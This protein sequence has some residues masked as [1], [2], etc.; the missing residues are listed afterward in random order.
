[1]EVSRMTHRQIEQSREIRLWV[2][3][4]F[5]PAVLVGIIVLKNPEARNWVK[6]QWTGATDAIKQKFQKKD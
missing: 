1:M 4:I 6:K 5:T 2:K 3:D